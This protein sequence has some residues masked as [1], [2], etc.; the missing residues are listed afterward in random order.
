MVSGYDNNISVTIPIFDLCKKEQNGMLVRAINIISI[1][2][3]IYKTSHK[4]KKWSFFY[5]LFISL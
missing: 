1:D 3:Y 4:L 2:N 5:L